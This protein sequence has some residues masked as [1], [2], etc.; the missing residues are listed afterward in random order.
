MDFVQKSVINEDEVDTILNS[1]ITFSGTLEAESDLLIKGSFAGRLICHDELYID[2]QAV[3]DA[4][5]DALS[6]SCRGTLKG[7]ARAKQSIRILAGSSVS[8]RLE[9]PDIFIEDKETFAGMIIEQ[10]VPE[11]TGKKE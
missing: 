4:E 1:D 10:P 3:V 2:S 8:A 5:I 6:I 7:I 9:A 11:E